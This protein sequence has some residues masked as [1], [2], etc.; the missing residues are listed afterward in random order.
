MGKPLHRHNFGS[1]YMHNAGVQHTL[2]S[3][4]AQHAMNAPAHTAPS[5]SN[6]VGGVVVGGAIGG[7]LGGPIGMAIGAALG[8]LFSR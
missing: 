5:K 4:R 2:D 1:T 3:R 7:A 8:G 6:V